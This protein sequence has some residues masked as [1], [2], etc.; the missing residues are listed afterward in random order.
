M[1]IT[2]SVASTV[3]QALWNIQFMCPP[4]AIFSVSCYRTAASLFVTEGAE[5]AS[6][7]GTAEG[8]PLFNA[9]A[10]TPL[11]RSLH[12]MAIQV[13]YADDAQA[14]GSLSSVRA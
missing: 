9:L 3:Q 4:V 7:E 12:G 2:P 6:L 14:A 5:I 13:W 8:D 1:Q 10:I 11:I